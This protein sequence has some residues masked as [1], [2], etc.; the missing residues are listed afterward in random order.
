MRKEWNTE[1][2]DYQ[3][4]HIGLYKIT[5]IA[6]KMDRS[7][8]SVKVK[9][10]R[11]GLSNTKLNWICNTWRTCPSVKGGSEYGKRV[12][13]KT[14]FTVYEKNNKENKKFLF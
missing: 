14:W 10:N 9:M 3:E 13:P 7:Y 5:T 4:E 8:E 12:D 1:D 11:L 6:Q 2:I